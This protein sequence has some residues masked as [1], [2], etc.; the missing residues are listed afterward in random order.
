M[1]KKLIL[2]ALAVSALGAATAA[3]SAEDSGFYIGGGI[4]RATL[5]GDLESIRINGARPTLDDWDT[6]WRAIVGYQVNKYLALQVEYIDTGTQELHL[7]GGIGFAL[8]GQTTNTVA[9]VIGILPITD[10]ISVYGKVG[11]DFYDAKFQVIGRERVP[12][13][14][15][16]V[17]EFFRNEM[18]ESGEE[19]MYGA[20]VRLTRD[21]FT[22]NLQYEIV[23]VDFEAQ[24]FN[25][26]LGQN[27]DLNIISLSTTYKF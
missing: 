16:A 6:A 24:L 9:S 26:R 18:N 27:W 10:S 7:T 17:R 4:G 15:I 19:L 14:N 23:D 22:F 5:S 12:P 1:K 8:D 11:Y 21:A 25:E 20:G 13:D 2:A 3:Q